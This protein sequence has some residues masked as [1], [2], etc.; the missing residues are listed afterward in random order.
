MRILQ[1]ENHGNRFYTQ[2]K[3]EKN[4]FVI[5]FVMQT[6]FA[7]HKQSALLRKEKFSDEKKKIRNFLTIELTSIN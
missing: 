5:R 7:K 3:E 1:I 4:K 6:M 2:S